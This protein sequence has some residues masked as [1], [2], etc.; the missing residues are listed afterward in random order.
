[1]KHNHLGVW[2][3]LCLVSLHTAQGLEK[4]KLTKTGRSTHDQQQIKRCNTLFVA[5]LSR[6]TGTALSGVFLGECDGVYR[7]VCVCNCCTWFYLYKKLIGL[8][9]QFNSVATT[10]WSCQCVCVCV[11]VGEH[12]FFSTTGSHWC[13]RVNYFQMR[14][15]PFVP[16]LLSCSGLH[17]FSCLAVGGDSCGMLTMMESTALPPQNLL[18]AGLR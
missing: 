9:N 6:A 12:F 18:H 17:D 14:K 8:G 10:N 4:K 7:R 5:I 16:F 11:W 1:M 3:R 15:M 13:V 2:S